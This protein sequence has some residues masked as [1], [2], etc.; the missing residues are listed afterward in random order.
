[1]A[2]DEAAINDEE[3]ERKRN[4]KALRIYKVRWFCLPNYCY[5]LNHPKGIAKET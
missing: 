3:T 2:G 1:M 4:R 5:R